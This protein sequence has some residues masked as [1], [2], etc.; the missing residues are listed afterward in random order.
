MTASEDSKFRSGGANAINGFV[1]QLLWCAVRSCRLRLDSTPGKDP[2]LPSQAVIVLEP[3]DGGDMRELAGGTTRVVQLKSRPSGRS[4]SLRDLIVEVLPDLYRAV[5]ISNDSIRYLMATE[6]DMGRWS[7]VMDFF[8]SLARRGKADDPPIGRLDGARVLQFARGNTTPSEEGFFWEEGPYSETRLFLQILSYLRRTTAAKSDPQPLAAQKL[9]HLLS[10][11]QFQGRILQA[12]IEQDLDS[13]LVEVTDFVEDVPNKRDELIGAMAREAAKGHAEIEVDDFLA[14][15]GLDARPLS[16]HAALRDRA[17]RLLSDQLHKRQYDPAMDVRQEKAESLYELWSKDS[18]IIAIDGESGVG[19]SWAAYALARRSALGPGVTVFLDAKGRASEDLSFIAGQYWQEIAD[20]DQA[21]PISRIARRQE[22][23]SSNS[24]GWLSVIIDGVQSH[25]EARELVREPFQSWG[26]RVAIFGSVGAMK[27]LQAAATNHVPM[28]RVEE[29]SPRQRDEYLRQA[30]GDSWSSV[31]TDVRETLNRPLLARIYCT[32]VARSAGWQPTNEYELYSQYWHSIGSEGSIEAKVALGKLAVTILNDSGDYPWHADLLVECGANDSVSEECI[33]RGWLQQTDDDRFQISHSRLL[34]FA[35][36]N[37][38]VAQLRLGDI[39]ANAITE[40][41]RELLERPVTYC[42]Q[43][44]GYVPMDVLYLLLGQPEL[45]EH[46]DKVVYGLSELPYHDRITLHR[47]LLPTLGEAAAEL[48]LSALAASA[49]KEPYHLQTPIV[50]GLAKLPQPGPD[51]GLLS[52]LKDTPSRQIAAIRVLGL[53]P[54]PDVLPQLWSIHRQILDQ[55]EK[56]GESHESRWFLYRISFGALKACVPLNPQWLRDAIATTPA[57][58]P[59]LRDLGYLVANLGDPDLWQAARSDL[60]AKVSTETKRSVITCVGIFRD[61]RDLDLLVESLGNRTD[62]QGSAALKALVRIDPD[63]ALQ[64]LHRVNDFDLYA[65]RG[66]YLPILLH[67]HPTRT[68]SRLRSMMAD[69]SDPWRIAL[70]LQGHEH[71][72]DVETTEFLLRELDALFI[73]LKQNPPKPNSNPLFQPLRLL[74]KVCHPQA[75]KSFTKHRHRPLETALVDYLRKVGPHQFAT[76]NLARNPGLKV[77]LR[78]GGDGFVKVLN[79]YI[80][81]SLPKIHY[82]QMHLATVKRDAETV[83]LLRAG[84]DESPDSDPNDHQV[85]QLA[86]T[87]A[88]IGDFEGLRKALSILGL[89]ISPAVET[90]LADKREQAKTA[91]SDW[92]DGVEGEN[93]S[94]DLIG[95]IVAAALVRRSSSKTAIRTLLSR[96]DPLSKVAEA[97]VF[98]LGR[99]ECESAETLRLLDTQLGTMEKNRRWLAREALLQIGTIDSLHRLLRDAIECDDLPAVLALAQHDHLA[100]GATSWITE[101][102]KKRPKPLAVDDLGDILSDAT[103]ACLQRLF[104]DDHFTEL[105]WEVAFGSQSGLLSNVRPIAVGA[106]ATYDPEAAISAARSGLES[107]AGEDRTPYPALIC[108]IDRELGAEVL[109]P[110]CGRETSSRVLGAIGRA[111]ARCGLEPNV[112]RMLAGDGDVRRAACRL[113]ALQP[114]SKEIEEALLGLIGDANSDV[115]DAAIQALSELRAS[116]I[117]NLAA[118]AYE[119]SDD[120]DYRWSIANAAIAAADPGDTRSGRPDWAAR[121]L[122]SSSVYEQHVVREKL[123]KRRKE[124]SDRE[125]REDRDARHA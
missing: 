33:R 12:E 110:Q 15:H 91:W 4:W 73:R 6:A 31:P 17:S 16:N 80:E 103:P 114:P 41:I 118:D 113:A 88:A 82:S 29:F 3:R 102:L 112:T 22:R 93:P 85:H 70:A 56:F 71:E 57:D 100:D 28:E 10:R 7:Q 111:F 117:A 53:R 90:Y 47:D 52:L 83:K 25:E 30:I 23:A 108:G 87:F 95:P 94:D 66:G 62:H 5:D 69:H 50:E 54:R 105:V 79:S 8:E 13:L 89:H 36:A 20:H 107:E 92:L 40:R 2:A 74:S 67:S 81:S 24:S 45:A 55:P 1:Y 37:G 106:L 63:R 65:G 64:E 119:D 121:I 78:I 58:D 124:I 116:R 101:R 44:L 68:L 96:A 19:K 59:H 125:E 18:P 27:A 120:Y 49:G 123:K 39:D 84:I 99:L 115:S 61:S 122:R 42:D 77:L 14:A 104:L 38:L 109:M 48:Q 98:A 97:C 35:V 11:F 46:R 86:D 72:I 51:R 26:V 60:L 34:N 32:Q 43:K 9:F 75:V 21:I 76:D